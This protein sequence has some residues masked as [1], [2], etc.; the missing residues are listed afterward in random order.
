MGHSYGV[1]EDRGVYIFQ[2]AR[3]VNEVEVKIAETP[4]LVL[5]SGHLRG[6]LLPMVVV[7]QL[8]GDEDVLTLDET[9]INGATDTFTSFGLVL[10]IISSVEKSV[11]FLYGLAFTY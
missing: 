11:S 1:L 3:E 2:C 4:G 9:S 10:I 6:I 5:L 8:G 7:P